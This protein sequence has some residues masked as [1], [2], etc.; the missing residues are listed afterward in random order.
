MLVRFESALRSLLLLPVFFLCAHALHAQTCSG[1]PVPGTISVASPMVCAGDEM[2]L[3]I[4]GFSAGN[5][6]VVQW[7][8]SA[9]QLTWT[10]ISGATDTPYVYKVPNNFT[11]T[12]YRAKVICSGSG[13][14]ATTNVLQLMFPNFTQPAPLP[15]AEDFDGDWIS[16]CKPG[17][18]P[19]PWA[20]GINWF[21]WPVSGNSSWRRDD[22]YEQGDWSSDFGGYS[23]ASTTGDHS[24]RFHSTYG[25]MG[26]LDLY[27]NANNAPDLEMKKLSFDYINKDGTDKLVIWLSVN[28]GV[29]FVR[30]DSVAT[31]SE[32]TKKNVFF[33]S[34]SGNVVIRFMGIADN[35]NSDI[36]LDNVRVAVA[37]PC[38][39]TP[40]IGN[41][42]TDNSSICA[43]TTV[44]LQLDGISGN[45]D[46]LVYQWQASAGNNT[47]WQ[48]I[49]NAIQ[50]TYTTTLTQSTWF[51]VKATCIFD[52]SSVTS[53]ETPVG[54]TPLVSGTDFTINKAQPTAGNNFASFNDAYAYL[55]C[56]IDGPVV[57]TV[58]PGSGPY[59]EQLILEKVPGASSAN[60]ITFNGN[61]NSIVFSSLDDN[62]RAVIKLRG[63]SYFEFNNLVINAVPDKNELDKRYGV[64]VHLTKNADSNVFRYCTILSDTL[65]SN[66]SYYGVMINGSEKD[67]YNT[68]GLCDKNIFEM[69]TIVGGQYGVYMASNPGSPNV[70]TRFRGNVIRDFYSRG[71]SIRGAASSNI[72]K[73]TFTC[74]V[75]NSTGMV[76][77]VL[78]YIYIEG[79]SFGTYITKNIFTHAF[80]TL[81]TSY[82]SFFGIFDGSGGDSPSAGLVIINN[83]FYDVSRGENVNGI[84]VSTAGAAIIH[85]TI[86]LSYNTI[87]TWGSLTGIRLAA[88]ASGATLRNN[89]VSIAHSGLG[90]AYALYMFTGAFSTDN[91]VYSLTGTGNN[92]VGY[93]DAGNLGYKTL[94]DWKTATGGDK[95]SV[96][97]DPLYVNVAEGD[98]HPTER[99]VNNIGQ[100]MSVEDDITGFTRSVTA[101]D[102]G[103]YEFTPVGCDPLHGTYTIDQNVPASATNF[104]SFNAARAALECGVSEPVVFDVKPGSYNEQVVFGRVQGASAVNTITFK[105]N[106]NTIQYSSTNSNE[107][108]V[109]KLRG[110]SHFVFDSLTIDATPKGALDGRYGFG[111]QLIDDADSNVVKNC[112]IL[113]DTTLHN[114]SPD[115][116]AIVLTPNEEGLEGEGD[117]RCDGDSILN[118]RISG[119]ATSVL[120]TGNTTGMVIKDNQVLNFAIMGISLRYQVIKALVEA[121]FISR[122]SRV[123]AG[124]WGIMVWGTGDAANLTVTRNTITKG[125]SP[126]ITS[127]SCHG[128][129]VY[130]MNNNGGYT[131]IT[132]NLIYNMHAAGG[133]FQGITLEKSKTIIVQH[134]TI[135]IDSVEEFDNTGAYGIYLTYAID[136]YITNNLVSITRTGPGQRA[137][138]YFQQPA[139]DAVFERNNYYLGTDPNNYAGIISFF[140][141]YKTL[142]EW[143]AVTNKEA[144]TFTINPLFQDITNGDLTPTSEAI[145][146]LGLQRGVLVDIKNRQRSF[147][148]PDMGAFE[149]TVYPCTAPPEAGKTVVTP[150]TAACMGNTVKLSL[151]GNTVGAGQRYVWQQATAA[152][153]P[154]TAISDT[155]MSVME[156]FSTEITTANYFR[157]MV[158]CSGKT[159]SSEVATITLNA[160]MPSGVYTI[161]PAVA[162]NY[163][164][165]KNFASFTEAVN[166]MACGIAGPVVFRAASATYSEQV[167]I[168]KIGNASLVNTV[169]FESASGKNTDVVLGYT[170]AGEG[171]N[172]VLKL[173]SASFVSF[174]NI[175]IVPGG[176]IYGNAVVISGGASWDTIAGCK[177]PMP[178]SAS[179]SNSDELYR[180]TGVL[181]KGIT[182][183]HNVIRGNEIINGSRS[184]YIAGKTD[185]LRATYTQIAD[186]I[187]ERPYA[188]G[189]EM[190]Y[191]KADSVS[192]NKIHITG[193]D[194]T[195][196]YGIGATFIDSAFFVKGNRVVL[197]HIGAAATAYGIKLSR[198]V[199]ATDGESRIERNLILATDANTAAM[200]ALSIDNLQKCIA[201]NN[202]VNLKTDNSNSQGLSHVSAHVKYYN[203][204]IQNAT[205]NAGSYAAFFFEREVRGSVAK[206]NIFSGTGGGQALYIYQPD[207]VSSDYNMLYTTGDVLASLVDVFAVKYSKL[208]EWVTATGNDR[209]SIVYKPAFA[210]DSLKPDVNSADVWAMHGRGVQ[211]AGNDADFYGATR[212]V[213][214]Q[215]GVPDLGAYEFLPTSV[216]VALTAVPAAPVAGQ[217]QVFYLGTDTVTRI[218]WHAGSAVPTGIVMRRYSGVAPLNITAGDKYMYFYTS[219]T[220]TGGT[221]LAADVQQYYLNPWQ[222][223][224]PEQ[225]SI[226]L[227]KTDAM[228]KWTVNSSSTVDAI[229]DIITEKGLSGLYLFTGL[230]NGKSVPPVVHSN[231]ST[232]AGT[233][234]WASYGHH[235]R[236]ETDN[237]QEMQLLM[238][239]LSQEAHVIITIP[240]TGWRQQYTI[241]PNTAISS[242]L[243]PKSG[244]YDARIIDEGVYNRGVHIV[245][246]VPVQVAEMIGRSGNISSN[247]SIEESGA[248]LLLPVGA[249]GYEYKAMI[250][251]QHA[252]DHA[253]SWVNVVAA[254]D[255]TLVSITASQDT[256]GGH[257]AGETY[258]VMLRKGEVYQ[259]M[260]R[261]YNKAQGYDLTGTL[262]RSDKNASG[263]CYPIAVFSGSSGTSI[264]CES[265][266]LNENLPIDNLVQQNL[267]YRAWGKR[268]ITAP[269][270]THDDETAALVSVYRVIV[271]DAATKVTVNGTE[272]AA[273]TLIDNHYYQFQSTTADDIVADKP[274]MVAQYMISSQGCP[275][276]GTDDGANDAEVFYLTPVEHG[277]K[278]VT[279]FRHNI[280]FDGMGLDGSNTISLIIPDEGVGSLAIDGVNGFYSVY[281]CV[282]IPGYSQVVKRWNLEGRDAS[283]RNTTFTIESDYPYTGITYGLGVSESYGYNLGMRIDT[284]YTVSSNIPAAADTAVVV[285]AGT[286]VYLH[287]YTSIRPAAITWH[288]SDIAGASPASDVTETNPAAKDSVVV[289]GIKY[290][291]YISSTAFSF[292]DTGLHAV[293][294]FITDERIEGCDHTQ[295]VAAPV[296]V[297]GKPFVSFLVPANA[298]V[299]DVITFTPLDTVAS[300]S[301]TQWQWNFGD[302]KTAVTHKGA[303]TYSELGVFDVK[304]T[305]TSSYGCTADTVKKVTLTDCRASVFVPNAFTPNGDGKNDVLKVYSLSVKSLHFMVFNQWG[306]KI[307]ETTNRDEGW[308]GTYKGARQPSGVYMYV[309][310]VTLLDGSEVVKKGAVNLVR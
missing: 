263:K 289:G 279:F 297:A 41:V 276:S 242:G 60:T 53:G 282:N 245:S 89:L 216:P 49:A 218:N 73:N 210:D 128:I 278:K 193:S 171:D 201:V 203:N 308:D 192:R 58:A 271:K 194:N 96:D 20:T 268:Y 63:A 200:Y 90:R 102:P 3:F 55:K 207:F 39:G 294:V 224:I 97:A 166:A 117:T 125:F 222:G 13:L 11:T 108:A 69:D 91:S 88:S 196:V 151:T 249:Y 80:G 99:K 164:S 246:D 79:F 109:I 129:Y 204:T 307:F 105:G 12:Y 232:S 72:E 66:Y 306:Q 130:G 172:Y 42:T 191:T 67:E 111:V 83:V 215:A 137:A 272:L 139:N 181:A 40:V 239:A 305:V 290:Y 167:R 27:L 186:N 300:G 214:L 115:F 231:D 1:T 44:N 50:T 185:V 64:G 6:I 46:G 25:S 54:I 101:P 30:L 244:S 230:L 237:L 295:E 84:F 142:A 159:D 31:A 291:Q 217:E 150:N 68:D 19:Q 18:R 310:S 202:V 21:N 206:N 162:T 114:Y 147:T 252:N 180:I 74:L 161:N 152:A 303:N 33:S 209:Y 247:A 260:G 103:A 213:T 132:N 266:M 243:L 293:P 158:T 177:I 221:A 14:S 227:G 59:N 241:A 253:W 93:F 269:V 156:P 154:W 56:G 281:P 5:D 52:N 116:G 240:G 299:G 250:T 226:K 235:Q 51:R 94:A 36:G 140:S 70:G 254:Y 71:I 228:G 188:S 4:T 187:L 296:Y 182:G 62:E 124:F 119:G 143:Q 107:R 287:T 57:F 98:L 301:I 8:S 265:G 267:P 257:K 189:V 256:K 85:N 178:V 144:N 176:N 23:P 26:Y 131:Q 113:A 9:D 174:H 211:I 190:M 104:L 283:D 160:G 236:F 149:F 225:D 82:N 28:G 43:A 134:N 10:D 259:V 179:G 238:G 112:N 110:A 175:S 183:S 220:T 233:E 302:G 141:H 47:S 35:G 208:D 24:A 170:A 100:A 45:T 86:D 77:S 288:I 309:C 127:S 145:D 123:E 138:V 285:C 81:K 277:V 286:A 87:A 136:G 95:Y 284:G 133:M 122:P 195:T 197:D 212:P 273:G 7:Q 298:C 304:F 37:A 106:G 264:V 146:N 184:I 262:V 248:T 169:R 261:L 16:I 32:W 251:K 15:Y 75:R 274:V 34:Y 292:A 199:A 198:G 118:N 223:F 78:S 219:A 61:H 165:G 173:D 234:F 48:D 255:S 157:C 135:S 280:G 258:T 38:S 2:K 17:S 65:S 229:T 163:P 275:G 29:D 153:G 155:L 168:P 205:V 76:T 121:N 22:K 270:M 148:T 126:E 120:I 92:Y